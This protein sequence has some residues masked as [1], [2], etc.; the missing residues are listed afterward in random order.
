MYEITLFDCQVEF[1]LE[2]IKGYL[3]KENEKYNYRKYSKSKEENFSKTFARDTYHQILSEYTELR[4][5]YTEKN[6]QLK[7]S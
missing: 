1:V 6:N 3:A 7:I 2:T 5:K 4:K